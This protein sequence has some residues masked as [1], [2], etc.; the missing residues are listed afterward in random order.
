MDFVVTF[1]FNTY[2]IQCL[3]ITRVLKFTQLST[4]TFNLINI[5]F[6]TIKTVDLTCNFIGRNFIKCQFEKA[7]LWIFIEALK[8]LLS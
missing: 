1:I 4:V 6:S 5:L 2:F 7:L 8:V 3:D